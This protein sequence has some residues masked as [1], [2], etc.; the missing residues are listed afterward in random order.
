M[1]I[2]EIVRR[3]AENVDF[4]SLI[5]YKCDGWLHNKSL[6][7]R[8]CTG[9]VSAW[10]VDTA[11]VLDA[12]AGNANF[13]I[14]H[15]SLFFN[16]S[17][18]LYDTEKEIETED[19][20]LNKTMRGLLDENGIAVHRF[21]DGVDILPRYG[22]VDSLIAKLELTADE[23]GNKILKTCTTAPTTV[24]ELARRCRR[25]L[26][27]G[28]CVISGDPGRIARKIGIS[29]GAFAWVPTID[30]LHAQKVDVILAGEARDTDGRVYATRLGMPV[31]ELGHFETE[32]PGIRN[33][34]EYVAG[35]FP[36]LTV[37]YRPS[38]PFTRHTV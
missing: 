17:G 25:M 28:S 27:A 5:N 21:H 33:F 22:V 32:E 4:Y 26:G 11:C 18:Y 19:K 38:E 31:I 2:S 23:G 29:A 30:I 1:K 15:E 9:I 7:G 8:K 36:D 34:T 20:E 13:I 24:E 16:K 10:M 37:R 14:S 3:I 35:L 6:G 12:A